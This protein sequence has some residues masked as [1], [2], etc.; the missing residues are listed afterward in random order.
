MTKRLILAMMLVGVFASCSNEQIESE[1]LVNDLPKLSNV[2]LYIDSTVVGEYELTAASNGF[3]DGPYIATKTATHPLLTSPTYPGFCT[4]VCTITYEYYKV[5]PHSSTANGVYYC[6]G[7]E[8]LSCETKFTN[9]SGG[10][11]LLWQDNATR[12]YY[13][14]SNIDPFLYPQD[15]I[16]IMWDGVIV[17]QTE[18]FGING[19]Y[20]KPIS[21]TVSLRVEP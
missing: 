4:L 16:Y 6:A 20:P 13:Q 3:L 12:A 7:A 8:I 2:L 19:N 15:L 18:F 10:F 14:S 9:N 1:I 21:G 5:Y 17:G 11:Y